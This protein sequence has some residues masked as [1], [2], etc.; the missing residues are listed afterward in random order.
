[1]TKSVLIFLID[2]NKVCL[3]RKKTG[4]GLGKWNGFGGHVE[5][6]ETSEKAAAREL[7]EEAKIKIVAS[8]L[9]KVATILYKEKSDWTVEVF[10]THSKIQPI[11]T[12]E[13]EPAWFD[14][15]TIPWDEMWPN[16][17]LWLEKILNGEKFE[18]TFWHDHN[19]NLLKYQFS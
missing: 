13:M 12:P 18:A 14:I 6:N 16:D 10:L 9:I 3:G 2:D 17:K 7:Y 19:G 1:M 15:S 5:K 4:H 8:E 11:E